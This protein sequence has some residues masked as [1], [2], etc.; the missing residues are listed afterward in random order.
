M[1]IFRLLSRY[2]Y[3]YLHRQIIVDY[4]LVYTHFRSISS[5]K[6]KPQNHRYIMAPYTTPTTTPTTPTTPTPISPPPA[7]RHKYPKQHQKHHNSPTHNSVTTQCKKAPH[8]FP[9]RTIQFSTKNDTN[10]HQEPHT[11]PSRI[12]HAT[13][14][15]TMGH[16]QRGRRK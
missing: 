8:K 15:N 12:T 14:D 5:T 10:F 4:Q 6:I 7:L 16:I 1:A 2:L 3:V 9:P 13:T 11:I